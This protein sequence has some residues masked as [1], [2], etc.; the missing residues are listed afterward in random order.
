MKRLS[1]GAGDFSRDMN[2][3][4]TGPE[5]ELA[6]AR[7]RIVLASRAAGIEAPIDSVFIDLKAREHLELST[8]KALEFGFQGKL[9]I[10]PDQ[11][12][13]VNDVFTPD[14]AEVSR[15]E[16]IIVAFEEA[17]ATGSA[18]IQV[19]G[20]FVDY[21]IVEKARRVLEVSERISAAS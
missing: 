4:W 19:D 17:E 15:A 1:F 10:H 9:C 18:S 21:P 2:L 8:Q 6:Y 12:G 20:Y 13:L 14:A 7:S 3:V 11:V 16:K 5:Q